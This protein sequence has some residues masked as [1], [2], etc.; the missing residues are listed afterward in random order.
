VLCRGAL[1]RV[2]CSIVVRSTNGPAAAGAQN[3][4]ETALPQFSSETARSI[5]GARQRRTIGN[6]ICLQFPMG[7]QLPHGIGAIFHFWEE[8]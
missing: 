6:R 2:V 1:I 5:E 7:A 3:R 4:V 8:A